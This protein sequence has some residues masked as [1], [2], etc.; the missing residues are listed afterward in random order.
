MKRVAGPLWRSGG[1]RHGLLSRWTTKL[2]RFDHWFK[3]R[4]LYYLVSRALTLL[5]RYG[6][7]SERA[8]DRVQACVALLAHYGCSPTFPTP[9]HVVAQNGAFCRELQSLGVELAIHG[10]DHIDFRSL[11]PEEARAQFVRAADAFRGSGLAFSGFRCPYL[12]CTEELRAALPDGGGYSGAYSSNQAIWWNVVSAATNPV[13][14]SLQGFYRAAS[15]EAVPAVPHLSG[16]LLEIPVSLPDDI[17]L[18]DG[19]KLGAQGVAAAW[20]EMLRRTHERG[21]LFVLLFHPETFEHC[22]LAFD[23]VLPEARR[24]QPAVWVTQLREVN[25]WW[26][27]QAGFSVSTSTSKG[28]FAVDRLIFNC[29]TRAT[30][31]LRNLPTDALSRPWY[32]PYRV[33]EGRSLGLSGALPFIGLAP[34]VPQRT[35]AFLREQG[36]IVETGAAAERCTLQLSR[37]VAEHSTPVGLLQHLEAA[38]VPLVRFWRWPNGARSALCVTGDLD[39]L[40]LRDYASR[41][42]GGRGGA[43]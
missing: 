40:S 7:T 4:G 31:L 22:Q 9:G 2:A 10:F 19:L 37:A 24:L 30:V 1:R 34:G 26:R 20:S 12:S 23:R 35:A 17:Q 28:A 11:S 41:L 32:G 3:Q 39:A 14:S 5:G 21:E 15:A 6:A 27:E 13:F 8:Q 43:R 33:L 42:I 18:L 36:F 29:S 38:P 25:R 16:D